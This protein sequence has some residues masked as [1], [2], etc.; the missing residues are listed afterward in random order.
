MRAYLRRPL[1]GQ[2]QERMTRDIA[3]GLEEA[4]SPLGVMVVVKAECVAWLRAR[5]LARALTRALTRVLLCRHTCMSL[6]GVEKQGATTVTTCSLGVFKT[7][8]ALRQEFL[9]VVAL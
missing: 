1:P 5:A 9:A 6:R 7:N 3:L 8:A 4:I 2:I